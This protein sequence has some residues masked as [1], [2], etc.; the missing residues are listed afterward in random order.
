MWYRHFKYQVVSFNLTNISV[1]FQVYINCVLYD[2]IDNFCIVYFDDILVFLKSEEEHYQHLQ[3]VIKHLC[4][5]E[6]YVNSKKCEFFKTEVKYLDF[7]VNE[8]S[9]YMNFFYI[10]TVSEWHSHLFKIYYNIQVFIRFCNFYQHFIY[11]FTDIT[12]SLHLLLHDM[13]KNKK[14]SLIA[15]EWQIFQ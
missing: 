1:I 6:L 14:S 3:L 5:T 4:H 15:D 11:N 9:L 7:L 13:K 12:W 2:L 10:K 8:K